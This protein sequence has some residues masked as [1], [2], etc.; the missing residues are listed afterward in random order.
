MLAAPPL[1]PAAKLRPIYRSTDGCQIVL[2]VRYDP[3]TI[4]FLRTLSGARWHT[5]GTQWTC[6]FTPAAAWRISQFFEREHLS[7]EVLDA[8]TAFDTASRAG[9]AAL[10]S[11]GPPA[12]A[13]LPLWPH[14]LPIYQFLRTREAGLL[15]ADMGTGKTA[16][17][18][19]LIV[20]ER[21][22]HTLIL[23]PT[24]VRAVWRREFARHASG[25][26]AV[27]CLEDGSV[28]AKQRRAADMLAQC[29][30]QRTPDNYP[31]PCAL[32][33]NYEAA[34]REPFA[35]W[36]LNEQW[37]LVVLDESHRIKAHDSA[38]SKFCAKLARRGKRRYCLTGTPMPHSPLDLF[39]QFRFLDRGLLGTSWFHFSHHYGVYANPAIPQQLTGYRHQDELSALSAMMTYRCEARDVLSLPAVRH[40]VRP[41]PLGPKA[42]RVY[43]DL[44]T[45]LI[46]EFGAGTVS[47]SNALVKLLRLQQVTSGF[48][49]DDDEGELHE[50]DDAKQQALGDLLTDI[51]AED[52]VVVFCRFRHD[53]DRVREAAERVSRR[54]GE[55]SG[56]Q[57]DLTPDATMPADI[58]VL[59]C[60]IAS[61]GVGID[62]TRARYAVYYSVCWSLGEY[63][64]SLAR[65]CRPGQ[66]RP[67]MYYHLVSPGTVD[68][69]VYEAFDQRREVIETVLEGY[70]VSLSSCGN[71]RKERVL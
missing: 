4:A 53:L 32:V 61:G 50:I 30:R 9:P 63:D 12:R 6:D 7:A 20:N 19:H 5:V 36:A 11:L 33:S 65:L 48:V 52:P 34:W 59:A 71:D 23:C 3:A 16:P 21:L 44:E 10:A 57:R 69:R 56:R 22:A 39:G 60:Q 28:A 17:V 67:V 66:T 24:S 47:A 29:A 51:P 41:C 8:A 62:L 31:L 42:R 14:Q 45:E 15:A 54:C 25:P 35:A 40:D 1:T 55:L 46:A 68:E 58:D 27:C 13:K 2:K 38:I 43:G 26:V 18:I 49:P 64:Q 70:R 37:D